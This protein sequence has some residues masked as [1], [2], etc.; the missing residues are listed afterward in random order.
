M[1]KVRGTLKNFD[2]NWDKEI[3]KLPKF[4]EYKESMDYIYIN[5]NNIAH[6]ADTT[7]VHR[8]LQ[9]HYNKIRDFLENLE[10][11]FVL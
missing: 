3:K 8:D 2:E 6:G 7:V 1:D 5:R 4:S 9:I 11:V 10:K